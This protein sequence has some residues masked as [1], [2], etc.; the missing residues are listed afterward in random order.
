M[1]R[2]VVGLFM[3]LAAT[4]LAAAVSVRSPILRGNQAFMAGDPANAESFYRSARQRRPS[5]GVALFNL[6]EVAAVEQHYVEAVDDFQRAAVLLSSRKDQARAHYNRGHALFRLGKLTEALG[7]FENALGLDPDD[8]DA[9]YNVTLVRS[10]LEQQQ[11]DDGSRIRPLPREE[12]ER[13]LDQT[14][15]HVLQSAPRQ[16]SPGTGPRRGGDEPD[17]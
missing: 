2:R 12:A 9:R 4:A 14:A 13:V 3:L 8:E 6:G 1:L 5:S 11:Q 10:L 16:A 15:T 7:A 17:K